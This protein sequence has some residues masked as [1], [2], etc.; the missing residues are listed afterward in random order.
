MLGPPLLAVSRSPQIRR[1]VTTVPATRHLV[2]RFVAGEHLDDAVATVQDLLASGLTVTVDRLGE[3]TVHVDQAVRT[4][5]AYVELL[6]VLGGFGLAPDAEVSLK[7]SA[8]GQALPEDGD[9]I[10]LDNA[11]AICEAAQQA[12]TTVTLDMED[13]TTVDSTLEILRDLRDDFPWVGAVLQ[14]CLRR[15][16]SDCRDLAR[17]GSRVRLVKG[18]YAEPTSVAHA[19]KHD[20]D[21]SYVRCLRTL[22]A[23]AGYPM[24]ATHDDRMLAIAAAIAEDAG[25]SRDSYEFQVLH[26]IRVTEQHRL[27]RAGHRMRVYLPYGADW[28]GYFVRRLAERP[29]NVSFFLRSLIR[30]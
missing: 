1:V 16:E 18:A 27:R 11:R 17:A 24:V 22:M 9:R 19:R 12:G 25:R 28:Y 15:T 5:D 13:H 20:V 6:G 23:G 29:A 14:T 8:V 30:D 3:D 26:G 21:R 4:R 10:A 2:D 7:L